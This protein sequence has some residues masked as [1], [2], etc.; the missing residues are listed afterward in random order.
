MDGSSE[1]GSKRFQLTDNIKIE[2]RHDLMKNAR[3]TG[4]Y[5]GEANHKKTC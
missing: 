5:V 4:K 3:K 2:G 1:E